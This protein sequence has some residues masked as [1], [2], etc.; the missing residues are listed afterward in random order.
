MA[1]TLPYLSGL[2]QSLFWMKAQ[3]KLIGIKLLHTLIWAI[4]AGLIFYILY[5]GLSGEINRWTAGA[6][7]LVFGEVLTLLIFQ[8]RCPLTLVAGRYTQEEGDNFDIYLPHWLARHNKLIF[9]G[10]FILGLLLV[11]WRYGWS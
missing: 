4:F 3:Q 8:W 1:L 5:S 9:G 2:A 6:I 7:I 10:L 11:A